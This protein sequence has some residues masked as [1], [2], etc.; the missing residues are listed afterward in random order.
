MTETAA[1]F[2]VA[3]QATVAN[4]TRTP[5]TIRLTTAD[6]LT[7]ATFTGHWITRRGQSSPTSRPLSLRLDCQFEGIRGGLAA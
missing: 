6:D 1:A 7:Y 5:I 4:D 2:D 3:Y